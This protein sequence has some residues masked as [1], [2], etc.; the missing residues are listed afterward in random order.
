MKKASKA[1]AKS[2]SKAKAKTSPGK[3]APKAKA[4]AKAKAKKKAKAKAAL[5]CCTLTGAGPAQ[6]I[7]GITQAECRARAIAAGKN[8]HWVPGKCAQPG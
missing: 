2:K 1:K 6:Q 4:K 8:D 7:E 5:G 3:S